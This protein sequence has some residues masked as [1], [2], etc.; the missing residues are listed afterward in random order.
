MS[1][2]VQHD[3]DVVLRLELCDPRA[4]GRRPL[5]GGN[6]VIHLNVEVLRG[7]LTIGFSG[8]ERGSPMLLELEV[9]REV[10]GPDLGPARLLCFSW[11]RG[12]ERGDLSAEQ[13][14]VELSELAGVWCCDSDRCQPQRR[15]K[16]LHETDSLTPLRWTPASRSRRRPT[17]CDRSPDWQQ[18]AQLVPVPLPDELRDLLRR[19]SLSFVPTVMPGSPQLTQTWVRTDGQNI[20]ITT[21]NWSQ[22]ARN[23]AREP[24][25]AVNIV[26]PGHTRRYFAVRG[27]VVAATTEGGGQNI[28]EISVK[29]LGRPYPN[30]SGRPE[31]RMILTS[32]RD[33]AAWA[34]ASL[35]GAHQASTSPRWPACRYR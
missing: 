20:L 1:R 5:D 21:P 16:S 27:R 15:R 7:G 19:P 2:R 13:F 30:F 4:A 33:S 29:Y 28:D 31:T 12:I 34:R 9:E 32:E 3:P 6:Q 10:R 22:K 26:D 8:P 24:R 23:V 14:G 18:G 17:R 25:V 11:A 35:S